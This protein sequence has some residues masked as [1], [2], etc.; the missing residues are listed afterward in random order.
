MRQPRDLGSIAARGQDARGSGEGL[1]GSKGRNVILG[2][3]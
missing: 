2:K 1:L 3:R